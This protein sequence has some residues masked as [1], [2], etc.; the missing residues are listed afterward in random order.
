VY[1]DDQWQMAKPPRT[2]DDIHAITCPH[3]GERL[4]HDATFCGACGVRLQPTSPA[5]A[6]A[7]IAPLAGDDAPVVAE[8]VLA[9]PVGTRRG[10]RGLLLLGGGALLLGLLCLGGLGAFAMATGNS[11][12]AFFG[13]A[14]PSTP[15]PRATRTPTPDPLTAANRGTGVPTPII[16]FIEPPTPTVTLTST[17]TPTSAASPTN[18]ATASA[19]PS[20]TPTA[21]L[22]PTAG[23]SGTPRPTTDTPTALPPTATAT[24]VAANLRGHIAY[25]MLSA[26]RAS[27]DVWLSQ[28][29][30]SNR[31]I[32]SPRARQP[33][34]SRDGSRLVTV[35]MG[36]FRAKLFIRDLTSGAE[37]PIENTPIEARDPS[38]SPDGQSV[39]YASTEL[40][41]RQAR[42]YI[43]DAR[44]APEQRKPLRFGSIDLFGRYPTWLAS[45]A[46]VYAGCDRWGNSG[47]CGIV[48]VNPDGN[49]PTLLT[50]NAR[51]GVDGAPGGFGGTVV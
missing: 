35:G 44:G 28:I 46:I 24:S 49:S 27:Y 33:Q 7:T 30:G 25:A 50:A 31:A 5:L 38:W 8:A 40:E 2:P 19:T 3:C 42:L 1:D 22:S 45:G 37:A 12:I 4:P 29:D 32:M 11:P 16:V 34:Y 39:V 20:T 26:N 41:D 13:A 10:P 51:D 6:L 43:V 18:A 48:R 9:E 15:T 17:A 47:Q 36:D 14:A 21:S 23:A